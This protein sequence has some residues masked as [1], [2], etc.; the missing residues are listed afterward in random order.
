MNLIE[1]FSVLK[2]IGFK[3][4]YFSLLTNKNLCNF[5]ILFTVKVHILNCQ[6]SIQIF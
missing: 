6:T 3:Q 1:I 4:Q 2:S 5:N